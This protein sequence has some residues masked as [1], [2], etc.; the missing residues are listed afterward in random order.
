MVAMPGVAEFQVTMFVIIAGPLVNVPVA[1]NCNVVPA[2]MLAVVGVTA[3][4]RSV[5]AVTVKLVEPVMP[6]KEAEMVVVPAATVVAR[7]W[8]PAALLMVAVVVEE[9]AQVTPVVRV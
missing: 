3:M 8:V 2:A 9:E 6:F 4:E 5:G 1:V 7:P